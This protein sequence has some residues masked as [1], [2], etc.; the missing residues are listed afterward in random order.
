MTL[1]AVRH[2]ALTMHVNP[3]QERLERER[4]A[5]NTTVDK[6]Q[7]KVQQRET[8]LADCRQ[9]LASVRRELQATSQQV[10][11]SVKKHE[12]AAQ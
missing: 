6:L 11:D 9:E 5:N 12:E 2:D 7:A 10:T 3:P 8:E 1:A 4:R